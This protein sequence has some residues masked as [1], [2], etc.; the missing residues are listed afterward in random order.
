MFSKPQDNRENLAL[1]A[2]LRMHD[3]R[4]LNFKDCIQEEFTPKTKLLLYE[5]RLLEAVR[6]FTGD[7]KGFGVT[8]CVMCS[9]AFRRT[10][11]AFTH[12]TS[13]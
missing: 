1:A 11:L 13:D 3:S 10:C 12:E 4:F 5:G 7:R 6:F 8:G 9:P 2:S